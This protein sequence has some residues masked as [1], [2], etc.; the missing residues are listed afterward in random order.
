MIIENANVNVRIFEEETLLVALAKLSDNR[1]GHLVVLSSDGRVTGLVT[2]GDIRRWLTLAQPIDLGV[3]VKSVCNA[4]ITT[5]LAD[6]PRAEI[7]RQLNQRVR[8]IPLV[9]AYGHLVSIAREGHMNLA[10]GKHRIGADQPVFIIAEI[11][12]NHNGDVELAK[13]LVDLAAEAGA[14]CAKFQMRDM[15]SLYT[16]KGDASDASQDLGAQY[17][18]DLLAKYNLDK[19]QLFEIFDHCKARGLEPLCTPWD[20][21][22]LEALEAYGMQGYKVASADLTNHE[23]LGRMATTG[24]TLICSTGMATEAEISESVALLRSAGAPFAL[25]HVNSTYPTPYKDVNLHYMPRLG[26]IGDCPFGYS[27][28]ERGWFVPVVA[29]GLGACVVEK[30]FTVDRSMEGNDHKVSLLPDEFCQMVEAI[31]ATEQARGSRG[32][33]T[34]T[35]GEMMNRE[36]LA[37]SLHAARD[38]EPGATIR[39]EDIVVR[40]PGQG[41]QPNRMAELIGRAIARPVASGTP[42]F[43][44]DLEAEPVTARDFHFPRPW[45]IPVR[46]HD[47][48]KMLAA[49]NLGLLEYHLSY[50]DMDEDLADWFDAPLDIDFTVHTPEL[51]AG[52][53]I[54]DLATDDP[55]YIERSLS[56]LNRVCDL[57]RALKPFHLKCDRP[58]IVTNMGGFRTHGF[59]PLDE[60]RRLYALVEENLK[61]VNTEGVEIIP[62]TMPPFPWHFGG[63]SHHNLFM[64]PDEIVEFCDRNG[65]RICFDVSH[66]QLACNH[67]GW[68]MSEFAR[69]VGPYTAHLHIVDAVGADGEGL[70]IGEGDMDFAALARVLDET[71]PDASFVPEIWQGHKNEGAGFWF[72]LDKLEPWM[73]R[74]SK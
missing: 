62:Q 59:L 56:E 44:S 42:F 13:R 68:S 58:V 15:A 25:L 32:A 26:E 46:Y 67:F 71:C 73:G 61:R 54:L 3:A 5:L 28:H 63:Q 65:M 14:D 7:V 18:L 47:Y 8:L 22:S 74:S 45:G 20:I 27:G 17:T 39:A 19:D 66:S 60:R 33:R 6:T 16:S 53:H 24:K 51:F 50:K 23:L 70:Q 11:G 4:N 38:L 52:D 36:V 49:T 57:T 9:D 31:R 34:V 69:K 21:A 72:A 41:L 1:L 12:N 64:D 55:D 43:P 40:S 35:Q 29:V 37:K 10:I 30:H 48:R 2:D